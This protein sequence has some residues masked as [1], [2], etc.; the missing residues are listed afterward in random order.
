MRGIVFREFGVNCKVGVFQKDV[1]DLEIFCIEKNSDGK[2]AAVDFLLEIR[3]FL[4]GGENVFP[5]S[6]VIF[7]KQI[8]SFVVIPERRLS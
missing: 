7:V 8:Q 4:E 2:G 3:Y 1:G 5:R 6:C